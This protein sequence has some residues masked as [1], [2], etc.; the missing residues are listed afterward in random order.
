MRFIDLGI[1]AL[2]AD[3]II[4]FGPDDEDKT[5]LLFVMEG[6][7]AEIRVQYLSEEMLQDA[8]EEVLDELEGKGVDTDTRLGETD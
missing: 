1:I 5:N 3:R 6:K 8:Y 4:S 7:L 2:C